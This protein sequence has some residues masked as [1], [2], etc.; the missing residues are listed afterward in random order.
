MQDV[1]TRLRRLMRPHLLV[2]AAKAAASLMPDKQLLMRVISSDPDSN[3]T[4]IIFDLMDLE[5]D[6]N[7]QRKTG[8]AS[9]SP[10]RH[11]DVLAAVQI[12]ARRH[13]FAY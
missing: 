3:L 10:A 2:Q 7:H 6:Q 8:Q 5:A 1:K 12:L 11:I 13:L 4:P 9:Y